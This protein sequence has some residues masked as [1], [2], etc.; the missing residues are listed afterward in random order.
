MGAVL[1]CGTV[2]MSGKDF[3][4][5]CPDRSYDKVE[6]RH[7]MYVDVQNIGAFTINLC[8]IKPMENFPDHGDSPRGPPVYRA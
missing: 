1:S 4:V 8:F 2:G 5:R 3:S 6:V 7:R